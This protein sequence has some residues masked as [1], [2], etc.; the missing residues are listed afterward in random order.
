MDEASH[1]GHPDG[2]IGRSWVG[3]INYPERALVLDLYRARSQ[4]A[5]LRNSTRRSPARRAALAVVV[6]VVVVV[7]AKA[8]VPYHVSPQNT[9]TLSLT[10]WQSI[11]PAHA[12]PNNKQ[13]TGTIEQDCW[14]TR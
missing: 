11:W 7:Q 6:V 2:S 12:Q 3:D 10:T 8:Q 1:R 4:P 13:S 9:H 5:L 14:G